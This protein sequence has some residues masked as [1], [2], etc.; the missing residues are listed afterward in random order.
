MRVI[1][2]P[3]DGQDIQ[4]PQQRKLLVPLKPAYNTLNCSTLSV[5]TAPEESYRTFP[6][7]VMEIVGSNRRFDMLVPSPVD[8]DA[9]IRQLL[10]R[11]REVT[12]L[13]DEARKRASEDSELAAKLRKALQVSQFGDHL[14]SQTIIHNVMAAL[15]KRQ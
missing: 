15:E 12:T 9:V 3:L 11:Y 1:G 6:Y 2:G 13:K 4:P 10:E 7:E 5:N 8:A 14:H